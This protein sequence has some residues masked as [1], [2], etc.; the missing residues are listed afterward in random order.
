MRLYNCSPQIRQPDQQVNRL[1]TV[2]NKSQREGY[3][4]APV[5]TFRTH[6]PVPRGPRVPASWLSAIEGRRAAETQIIP[7]AGRRRGRHRR[8]PRRRQRASRRPDAAAR[9][10]GAGQRGTAT[11]APAAP[12][13]APTA[14]PMRWRGSTAGSIRSFTRAAPPRANSSSGHATRRRLPAAIRA[15]AV[16]TLPPP[17]PAAPSR[18]PANWAAQISARQRA[19]DGGPAAAAAPAAAPRRRTGAADR[20]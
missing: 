14:S 9:T 1:F 20:T 13:S 10:H 7:R 11:A 19:L 16:R 5:A 18:G 3:R 15:A 4:T 8:R 17:P 12:T 2:I 6:A